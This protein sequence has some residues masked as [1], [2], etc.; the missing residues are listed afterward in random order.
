[1]PHASPVR[2]GIPTEY[3]PLVAMNVST[4]LLLPL[5][6]TVALVM[7]LSEAWSVAERERTLAAD[8]RRETRAY[9][10]AL[11]LALESAFEDPDL[12][13]A[14]EVIG[15]VG[16]EPRL[17][18]VIVYDG[19]GRAR[20]ATAPARMADSLPSAAVR[21]VMRLG[22]TSMQRAIGGEDAYV[23]VEPLRDDA[24]RAVGA[25]EVAQP[26]SYVTRETERIALRFTAYTLLLLAAVTAVI[27]LLVRSLVARPLD[28]LVRGARAVGSGELSHRIDAGF[29]GAELRAVA[30]EFNRMAEHLAGAREELLAQAE[31]RVE[32]ERRLRN[33]EKL[34]AVGS[35]AAGLAHEIGAPLH[36]IRGR[37]ETLLRGEA[38]PEKAE[39]NLRII[40]EQIGRI[41]LIVRNLLDFS[42][43]REPRVETVDVRAA[44]L[45]VLELLEGETRR[46]RVRVDTSALEPADVR[47]D[48]HLLQQLLFNLIHNAVQAMESTDGPR[49]V[50]VSAHVTSD[51]S[52]GFTASPGIASP[53]FVELEVADTGPGIP[54]EVLP[55][56]FEPFFTTKTGGE[57][58]G[59][60]LAV[61]AGIAEEHGAAVDARTIR[62]A[63]GR[64]AG[65]AFRVRFPAPLP[66]PA[67]A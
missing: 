10:I 57:G 49:E 27:L 42:R 34:A 24:G 13:D 20:F 1:L 67:H 14:A 3:E 8:G 33:A 25:Y 51:S 35:L 48:P 44:A 40:V 2:P 22:G 6:A 64:P 46:A 16:R 28:R 17:Y 37:A 60:G 5:L 54:D 62:D 32:M 58:T 7:A 43:R 61:V 12:S 39:R 23:V 19:Q 59:L 50:R 15:R 31:E 55:R 47:A 52:G 63:E 38:P 18:G 11:G 36:V 4:R 65:A 29:A 56:V 45:R 9:A 30:D 53:A 66:E 41:T 21:S 26:M